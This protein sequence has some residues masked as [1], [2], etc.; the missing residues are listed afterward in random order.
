MTF[1]EQVLQYSF[2]LRPDWQLPPGFELLFPYDQPE[3]MR[4]MTDFYDQFYADQDSRVF[5]FGINPGRFGAG[6]TGVPF[7][8]PIRLEQVCG[9]QNNFAKKPELSSIFVYECINAFGCLATFYQHFY[10]TS[11][12]PLGFVKAGKNINYYDDKSLQNAVAPH[13]LENI[14]CQKAFGA[15]EKVAICLGQG[16]N[17][18][19]FRKI[20]EV[21]HFFELILE[22][23]HP[24]WVMQYRRKK[25]EDFVAQYIQVLHKALSVAKAL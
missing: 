13:I 23:P 9:I 18:A 22:V 2:S 11:L 10:I 6:V 21:H 1:A 5:I 17:A 16:K 3:T 4:V 8:D 14:S 12:C 15:S 24:R 7:T 25:M 20:N 19:Y